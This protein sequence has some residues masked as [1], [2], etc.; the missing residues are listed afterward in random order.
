MSGNL[1]QNISHVTKEEWTIILANCTEEERI[2]MINVYQRPGSL[3]PNHGNGRATPTR[4]YQ[5]ILGNMFNEQVRLG[6][7]QVSGN[8]NQ[9][10][11]SNMVRQPHT[12]VPTS[13]LNIQG[14]P[15]IFGQQMQ[16]NP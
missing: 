3:M 15:G 8:N 5:N 1:V 6:E 2:T 14:Q 4:A 9:I 13:T 11:V 7:A 12:H 10:P 16:G